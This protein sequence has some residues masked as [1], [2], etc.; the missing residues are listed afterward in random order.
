MEKIS[1]IEGEEKLKRKEFKEKKK[2]KRKVFKKKIK[3]I[4]DVDEGKNEK[5]ECSIINVGDKKIKVEWLRNEKNI[6]KSYS[7][8]RKNEL[9]F[10]DL[11]M[12]NVRGEDEGV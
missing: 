2:R 8:K 3:K 5:F 12:K 4:D 1:K 11:E 9:G 7:I 6:E 10:V